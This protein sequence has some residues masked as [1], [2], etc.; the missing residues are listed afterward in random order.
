MK[1]AKLSRGQK[2]A[3]TKKANANKLHVDKI[4]K[5]V[6][7]SD[8]ETKGYVVIDGPAAISLSKALDNSLD[9]L[10]QRMIDYI[11]RVDRILA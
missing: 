5:V 2:A 3:A 8:V 7:P 10:E 1:K 4:W 6:D 11:A 9:R